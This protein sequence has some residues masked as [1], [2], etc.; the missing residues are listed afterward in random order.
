MELVEALGH[1]VAGA[2]PRVGALADGLV[3]LLLEDLG[4]QEEVL[5]QPAGLAHAA[6]P[7][8]REAAQQARH[9]LPGARRLRAA[10]GVDGGGARELLEAGR[11][12]YRI[13][14]HRQ[15]IR[16]QR[17]DRDPDDRRCIGTGDRRPGDRAL[18][19]A[20]RPSER[21]GCHDRERDEPRDGDETRAGHGAP[22]RQAVK[23]G[24][25]QGPGQDQR[26]RHGS[27]VIEGDRGG[28]HEEL[29]GEHQRR[30]VGCE[31][32]GRGRASRHPLADRAGDPCHARRDGH[33]EERETAVDRGARGPEVREVVEAQGQ[34]QES[35]AGADEQRRRPG[36]AEDGRRDARREARDR[37]HGRV[38]ADDA[39]LEADR[40]V[41]DGVRVYEL[42]RE[43]G[44]RGEERELQRGP[45]RSKRRLHHHGP[46]ERAHVSWPIARMRARWSAKAG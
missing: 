6:V 45:D 20:R 10:G 12:A 36:T 44:G 24:E 9:R 13:A 40:R 5:A 3:A 41:E 43:H 38:Q 14:V 37:E 27:R 32:D 33:R 22:D 8:R 46:H 19:G 35:Q 17:V 1:A 15:V 23:E 28:V 4:Q 39:R 31:E 29:G 25:Q 18:G 7:I 30:D 42:G 26:E 21:R 2:H 16:A 11:G 34:D